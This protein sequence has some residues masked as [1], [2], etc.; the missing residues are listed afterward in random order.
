MQGMEHCSCGGGRGLTWPPA[1]CYTGQER[2]AAWGP[3]IPV[4]PGRAAALGPGCCRQPHRCARSNW[5]KPRDPLPGRVFFPA[6]ARVPITRIQAG[7]HP[8]APMAGLGTAPGPLRTLPGQPGMPTR[9]H[10]PAQRALCAAASSAPRS[11]RPP[12]R[13]GC[14]GPRCSSPPPHSGLSARSHALPPESSRERAGPTGPHT[15]PGL[16]PCPRGSVCWSWMR[17]PAP[18]TPPPPS[19]QPRCA[20][21]TAAA[22][23][24]TGCLHRE[25]PHCAPAHCP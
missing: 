7:L 16:G 9:R 2:R 11:A 17:P 12:T 15:A 24:L 14:S 1:R 5:E 20:G 22:L 6:L 8:A 3:I 19:C 4:P 10:R 21:P 13:R 25:Y 18:S 23:T